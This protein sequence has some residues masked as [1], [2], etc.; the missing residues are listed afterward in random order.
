V[1]YS[2]EQW[3][4]AKFLF[5]LGMS[6]RQIEADCKI[7]HGQIGKRARAEQWQKDTNKQALKADI[8]E[9]DKKKDTL[10]KEKDTLLPKIATLKDYEVTI[11]DEIVNNKEGIKN[12][13][14]TTA[15]LSLI[16]KNQMLTKNTKQITEY[17]TTY[18]DDGKPL[19]K[20]PTVIEV[21][22]SPNDLKAIDEGVD[23]NAVSL[24]VA[25]RHANAPQVAIQNNQ[26]INAV[27]LSKE[28]MKAE[29][30]KRG[31]PIDL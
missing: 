10:D 18:S 19:M 29:L 31:L 9:L 14:L 22:L 3:D 27:T 11:L 7:A 23:K 16:R 24:E 8:I 28:E 26:S 15:T 6:L 1:A 12:F 13:V 2:I 20:K 21:E 17:E 5:E 25:P 4:R 30:V